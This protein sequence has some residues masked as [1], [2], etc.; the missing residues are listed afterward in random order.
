MS[1]TPAELIRRAEKA[2]TGN[3]PNLACLYM[4]KALEGLG[5]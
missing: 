4:N 1:Y 3:Q 5:R 2:L